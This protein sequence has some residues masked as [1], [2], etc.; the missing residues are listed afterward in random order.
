MN[1]GWF[2]GSEVYI[3]GSENSH[4]WQH[5][6]AARYQDGDRTDTPT[7]EPNALTVII[8]EELGV[9]NATY[10][11]I[12]GMACMR[13]EQDSLPAGR[14]QAPS[15]HL[16]HVA[17]A[18]DTDALRRLHGCEFAPRP[19]LQRG[20]GSQS[21]AAGNR[22]EVARAA[23]VLVR[24][25]RTSARPGKTRAPTHCKLQ[26]RRELV[27]PRLSLTTVHTPPTTNPTVKMPP[28]KKVERGPAENIQVC[29]RAPATM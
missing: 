16:P 21:M 20:G 26:A 25:R 14:T 29:A 18:D 5:V 23:E 3:E 11:R 2:E 13:P 27:E 24:G 10:Q 8:A 19:R 9:G 1:W 7:L 4:H 22:E 28:K 17:H 6:S 15:V 12:L